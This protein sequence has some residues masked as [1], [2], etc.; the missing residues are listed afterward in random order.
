MSQ[1]RTDL[2]ILVVGHT[3]TGKT[4]YVKRWTGNEY[5]D[6]Y[7]PTI[8]SEFSFKIHESKGNFYRI[9][10]WDI[11]GQDKSSSIAK[12]FARDSHGC[13]V[14]SDSTRSE[15]LKDTL[16]WKKIISD[17]TSFVD[18]G[19]LPF[20][21]VQNKVDLIQDREDFERIENET[22][23]ICEKNCFEKYFMGSVKQNVNVDESM[24]YLI[25]NII[26][27]MEKHASNGNIVFNEQ[28]QRNSIVITNENHKKR[29]KKKKR[30]C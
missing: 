20:I 13:V 2:K 29:R 24:D 23:D 3:G 18:G 27:R 26:D 15:T 30:W 6:V 10:L 9:Q 12:I 25:E 19:I 8:G 5:K 22:K 4:S 14:I 17:E 16:N 21:L 11:G 7:K 1:I 28:R